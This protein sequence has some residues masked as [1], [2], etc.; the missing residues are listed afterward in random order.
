MTKEVEPRG[1]SPAIF[2][3]ENVGLTTINGVSPA[4]FV[5]KIP[6]Y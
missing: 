4:I 5:D 2:V 3:V 6:D 1:V